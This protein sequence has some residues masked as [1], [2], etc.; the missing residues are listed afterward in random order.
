M[1]EL[2]TAL[3]SCMRVSRAS[4]AAAGDGLGALVLRRRNDQATATAYRHRIRKGR[5][6]G[7]YAF[8]ALARRHCDRLALGRQD[9]YFARAR[10]S[11]CEGH[12]GSS[13][14]YALQ[15]RPPER[16]RGG[17]ERVVSALEWRAAGDA[18][19]ARYGGGVPPAEDQN[20]ADLWW[21]AGRYV[22]DGYTSFSRANS[23]K[24]YTSFACSHHEADGLAQRIKRLYPNVTRTNG[25]TGA[26]FPV[27][28]S[29][30][31]DSVAPFRA[32]QRESGFTGMRWDCP[33]QRRG[34]TRWLY[35]GRRLPCSGDGGPWRD[36]HGDDRLAWTAF[37]VALLAQRAR[38]V[39][40]V[41]LN[42]RAK[43]AVIQ[44][45]TVRQRDAYRVVIPAR[46]TC[47]C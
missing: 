1:Y 41:Y 43:T 5:R 31:R 44:G 3:T 33:S 26:V 20:P 9:G 40:A 8:G 30:L 46:N 27:A 23:G 22:A 35:V 15:N 21:L 47:L 42:R 7:A 13:I 19:G 17:H 32:A 36:T 12:A 14:T 37:G 34:A 16:S 25:K 29:S 45:R 39:P 38:V 28:H 18:E 2:L 11:R 24:G 6:S 4:R 10:H